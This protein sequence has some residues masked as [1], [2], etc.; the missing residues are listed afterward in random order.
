MVSPMINAP[1]NST[2]KMPNSHCAMVAEAVS[3]S[4]K[5][6]AR[7]PAITRKIKALS[8]S[9][10]LLNRVYVPD[11]EKNHRQVPLLRVYVD[12]AVANCRR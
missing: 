2:T 11:N 7:D 3:T 12:P 6:N 4:V 1:R 8:A 9:A 10:T 5:P